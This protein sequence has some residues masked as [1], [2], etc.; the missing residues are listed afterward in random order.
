M[1]DVADGTD[2]TTKKGRLCEA[3]FYVGEWQLLHGDAGGKALLQTAARDCP[4]YFIES[5][6]AK[7]E[8]KNG[9]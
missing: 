2:E 3:N 7:M 8:L 6:G 1:S 9:P 5:F 4:P